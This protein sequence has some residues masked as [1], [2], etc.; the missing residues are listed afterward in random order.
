[1][2]ALVLLSILQADPAALAA[3]AEK[4]ASEGRWADAVAQYQALVRARPE[5]AGALYNLAAALARSGQP[6]PSLDALERAVAAGF[7]MGAYLAADPDFEPVRTSARFL[8]AVE[9]AKALEAGVRER[10]QKADEAVRRAEEAIARGDLAAARTALPQT[11]ADVA[12]PTRY[13]F[14]AACVATAEQAAELLGRALDAG[15]VD[16]P[17]VEAAKCFAALRASPGWKALRQKLADSR[18]TVVEAARAGLVERGQ[19]APIVAL[20][21]YGQDAP[22]FAERLSKLAPG[23]R[24][25]AA[26]GPVDTGAG[27]GWVDLQRTQAVLDVALERAKDRPLLLGFSQGGWLGLRAG[28]THPTRYCG[29]VAIATSRFE[30]PPLEGARKAGL[31]VALVAGSADPAAVAAARLAEQ[32]LTAAGV[33]VRVFIATGLGHE[34][35][36]AKL[37]AEAIAFAAGRPTAEDRK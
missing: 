16:L 6:E 21:G 29:V 37:L 22:D 30:P 10:R 5:D 35:P 33:P 4:S 23:S 3:A 11:A 8:R 18:R 13:L 9:R 14:A 17:A 24:V 25:I 31:K 15:F 34:L 19:G 12:E 2:I 36:D 27:R 26:R 28:L 7:H 20:H 1:M 32:Q